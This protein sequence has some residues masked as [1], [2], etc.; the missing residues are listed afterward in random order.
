MHDQGSCS[1]KVAGKEF[2]P[3]CG[4]AHFGHD[5]ACPY[6][7]SETQLNAIINALKQSVES[8][9]LVDAADKYLRGVKGKLVQQRGQKEKAVDYR[10]MAAPENERVE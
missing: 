1:L 5:R 4:L 3:L 10:V 8:K 7:K 6:I 9:P 2:C